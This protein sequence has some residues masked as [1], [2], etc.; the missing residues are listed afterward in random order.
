M[1]RDFCVECDKPSEF[2]LI[3]PDLYCITCGW[4][5][6]EAEAIKAADNWE[7]PD[8]PGWEGGFAANH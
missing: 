5:F 8:P 1:S 6:D 4:T 2:E 3:G 7:P